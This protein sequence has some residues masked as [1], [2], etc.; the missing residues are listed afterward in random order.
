MGHKL[1]MV[2][3]PWDAG[4]SITKKV[5]TICIAYIIVLTLIVIGAIASQ[6]IE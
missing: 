6:G 2:E 3:E 5:A 1:N 4:M